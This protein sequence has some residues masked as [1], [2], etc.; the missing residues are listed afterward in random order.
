M[1]DNQIE[2]R[3]YGGIYIIREGAVNIDDLMQARPGC[4]IV[5]TRGDVNDSIRFMPDTVDFGCVAGWIS[6]KD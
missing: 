3:E 5:R 1:T 4:L 2:S 6:E